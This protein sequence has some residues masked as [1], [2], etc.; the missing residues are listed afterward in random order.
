MQRFAYR[1]L[2][3]KRRVEV[4]LIRLVDG[5]VPARPGWVTGDRIDWVSF[6]RVLEMRSPNLFERRLQVSGQRRKDLDKRLE[7][8][9]SSV[10]EVAGDF[11][12]GDFGAIDDAATELRAYVLEHPQQV[13]VS[14]PSGA[15]EADAQRAVDEVVA[16]V[17]P[18]VRVR[19]RRYDR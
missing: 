13:V 10:R 3:E 17:P 1:T 19:L 11:L 9:A 8:L 6:D 12:A 2:R 14:L 18:E 4:D 15:T 7:L 5:A 16:K